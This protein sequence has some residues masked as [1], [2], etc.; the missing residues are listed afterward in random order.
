L[1]GLRIAEQKTDFAPLKRNFTVSKS[2]VQLNDGFH[3]SRL[4]AVGSSDNDDMV[5]WIR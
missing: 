2:A 1:K 5:T 3:T 4:I